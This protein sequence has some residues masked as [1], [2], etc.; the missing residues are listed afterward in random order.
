MPDFTKYFYFYV[1]F[2]L[3]DNGRLST[4]QIMAHEKIFRGFLDNG[5]AF[6][7][8][9]TAEQLNAMSTKQPNFSES[10]PQPMLC[11]SGEII[12]VRL[13]RKD[14]K[15]QSV[16]FLP[17]KLESSMANMV[18]KSYHHLDHFL[19]RDDLVLVLKK[20]R[21]DMEC[22]VKLCE[23]SQKELCK[24]RN[25]CSSLT[26]RV[27]KLE[28]TECCKL[29]VVERGMAS[30]EAGW[31][32]KKKKMEKHISTLRQTV[33]KQQKIINDKKA[34]IRRLRSLHIEK[35]EENPTTSK[36]ALEKHNKSLVLMASQK[37]ELE[38]ARK[39]IS[40]LKRENRQLK[41]ENKINAPLPSNTTSQRI[42]STTNR[43][44]NEG[45]I[46]SENFRSAKLQYTPIIEE[47]EDEIR[48]LRSKL[49]SSMN[50]AAVQKSIFMSTQQ[51]FER[52]T[53]KLRV[54]RHAEKRA[55]ELL[56]DL[57]EQKK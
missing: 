23:K 54:S 11:K 39:Q 9:E 57:L 22:V 21:D 35:T 43:S 8:F 10:F 34:A 27:Q 2:K 5:Q 37:Q 7:I 49:K 29:N 1:S 15:L 31:R 26:K 24:S 33:N 56:N 19:G 46:R 3:D 18:E 20:V 4:K 17:N 48:K 25:L 52:A 14:I 40:R 41:R 30:L 13:D 44:V 45:K 50:D 6:T 53:S 47:Q 28:E 12:V 36:H 42:P 55:R 16:F 32:S 38:E 51:D